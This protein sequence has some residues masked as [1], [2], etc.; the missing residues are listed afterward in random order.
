[1]E[2]SPERDLALTFAPVVVCD[3]LA[4][5][6]ELGTVVGG[7]IEGVERVIRYAQQP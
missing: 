5:D 6:A 1:M 4:P 2:A 3:G 7:E